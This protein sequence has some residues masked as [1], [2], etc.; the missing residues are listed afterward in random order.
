VSDNL[1]TR[2][3]SGDA[4]LFE[5]RT[6]KHAL[7]WLRHTERYL[8]P[9]L[10]DVDASRPRRY[11]RTLLLGMG[12][13]SSPARLYAES[14]PGNALVVLD[15]S[16]PDTI[17]ATEFTEAT[18]I[19]SSKSG[20]TIETQALLA[21]ALAQ[22][23]DPVD[24]IVI[25]DPGTSLADLATA[26][27]AFLVYADPD[28][29]GRFSG[30]SP[31]GVV[32]AFYAGWTPD[33]LREELAA[34]EVTDVLVARA[35]EE[36][37][38]AAANI[39][40]G[41]AYYGLDGD[42]IASGGALWLEQ[43]I[44]ETTGKA[45][46]G[47]V[48]LVGPPTSGVRPGDMQRHHLV[49]ALLARALGVNPFDQ[50]DVE[51]AKRDVLALLT[52]DATFDQPPVD[53]AAARDAM[54][55]SRYIVIQAFAPLEAAPDIA[56]LRQRVEERFGPTTANLGPRYLHSTGQLHKGGPDGVAALQVVVRPR[57]EPEC[58]AGRRYTFHDLHLAQACADVRAMQ[59]RQRF[60][61]QLFVDDVAEAAQ[62]L[63]L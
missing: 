23:L 53:L 7:G 13:S 59:E 40:D 42:P 47:F 5:G 4:S 49:A 30:L 22:G 24:L 33:T 34:C 17:A 36:A 11:G 38:A 37:N 29:G 52:G 35:I 16:N 21:H 6:A 54:D 32:P 51:G 25:T 26:L 15:T 8:G 14:R 48:P 1:A 44:A 18:V 12:G 45:G 50:P 2:L 41:W 63:D 20:T 3:L 43:L 56:A 19:A 46:R 9:W 27:G 10:D 60:V 61:A 31:Y 58:I 62:L 57:S 28:T 55:A 39:A